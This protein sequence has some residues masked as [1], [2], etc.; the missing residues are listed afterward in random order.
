MKQNKITATISACLVLLV[1]VASVLVNAA[2]GPPSAIRFTPSPASAPAD[3]S[4]KITIDTFSFFYKC[5]SGSYVLKESECTTEYD[6]SGYSG[7]EVTKTT[8]STNLSGDAGLVLSAATITT[9]SSGHASFSVTS[10]KAGT[11]NLYAKTLSGYVQGQ[12]SITF[13]NPNPPAPK[14]APAK[15]QPVTPQK[16]DKPIVKLVDQE[17]NDLT[18]E[19]EGEKIIFTQEEPVVLSG[20][21]VP[22]GLIKLYIFSEPQEATVTAD[23]EGNW[24]YTINNLE[25]GDHRVEAE[26]T[27]PS[28]NTTSDRQQVLAFQVA[29]AEQPAEEILSAAPADDKPSPMIPIL[30]IL[31]VAVLGAGG[32]ALWRKRQA[33]AKN[34]SIN[35]QPSVDDQT[36]TVQPDELSGNDQSHN[37]D[38]N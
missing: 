5:N 37:S 19:S 8:E 26:V 28:T 20:T 14:P 4:S 13:T 7:Q 9:D 22:N 17:G 12:R 16:P 15:P 10:S 36:S 11:F 31:A 32:F 23:A 3:G 6:S 27:D 24:G 29:K 2:A 21:T 35:N 1:L 33:R 18:P 30:V 34:S 25:P 38:N